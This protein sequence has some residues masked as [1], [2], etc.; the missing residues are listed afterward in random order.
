MENKEANF[1]LP[2]REFCLSMS[3][4]DVPQTCVAAC[5][6]QLS[7]TQLL[8]KNCQVNGPRFV[9]A[10]HVLVKSR[11]SQTHAQLVVSTV[12]RAETDTTVL[13]WP[14]MQPQGASAWTH[15]SCVGD[16]CLFCVRMCSAKPEVQHTARPL[17]V[18]TQPTPSRATWATSP[19]EP[20]RP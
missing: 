8:N 6:R 9:F 13:F 2:R 12:G 14:F 18:S 3:R 15:T 1:C 20:S 16:R 19:R 7:S 11:L 4:N 10:R 5:Q 17:S